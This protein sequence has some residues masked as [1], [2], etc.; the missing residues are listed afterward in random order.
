M[1]KIIDNFLSKEDHKNILNIMTSSNFFWNLSPFITCSQEKFNFFNAY[2]THNF[3]N[4]LD[5][6]YNKKVNICYDNDQ[7][8]ITKSKFMYL[9]DCITDK[10]KFNEIIRIKGNLYFWSEKLKYHEQH[11]DYEDESIKGCV[12]FVNDNDGY[13]VLENGTKIESV[14]NRILFFDSSKMHNSTNCTNQKYRI[15]INLNYR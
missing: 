10:I 5:M 14:S 4:I 11:K 15:T 13:T 3:Y 2:M 8:I 6:K 9:I 1:Y 7:K 12:Y